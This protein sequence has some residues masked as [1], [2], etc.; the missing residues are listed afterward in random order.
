MKQ[1]MNYYIYFHCIMNC[2][3]IFGGTLHTLEKFL[4]YERTELERILDAE[5]ETQVQ[6]YLTPCKFYLLNY[7]IVFFS[8]ICS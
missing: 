5:V 8:F 7:N 3:T 4:K 2:R 1:K 6:I